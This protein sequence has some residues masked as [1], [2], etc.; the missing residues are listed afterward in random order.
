MR[1]YLILAT[2]LINT[3][4]IG[5]NVLIEKVL[6]ASSNSIDL[7]SI[8]RD[9]SLVIFKSIDAKGLLFADI[10]SNKIYL[11]SNSADKNYSSY[12]KLDPVYSIV[13]DVKGKAYILNTING[14]LQEVTS[15]I[16]Q[17]TLP[18][19]QY[20]EFNDLY[21]GVAKNS[22]IEYY[23]SDRE[24]TA[25]D[26]L[27]KFGD[28]PVVSVHPYKKEFYYTVKNA[29]NN[30]SVAKS[31]NNIIQNLRYPINYGESN[32]G[33]LILNSDSIIVSRKIRLGE[34]ELALIYSS[35]IVSQ[36]DSVEL[37]KISDVETNQID[38]IISK[39][40]FRDD[41]YSAERERDIGKGRWAT[42]IG[43][44]SDALKAMV[45]LNNALT[46]NPNSFSYKKD[47]VY[48]ILGPKREQ[49]QAA[50]R[51][52]VAFSQKGITT[53]T[54]DF[55]Y[56]TITKP[57]DVIIRLKCID[58]KSGVMPGYNA[59]FYEY[60]S[61]SVVKSATIYP[62]EVCYFSYLPEYTLGLT[63]NSIGYLPQSIKVDPRE[64]R[65]TTNRIEKI[66][67]LNK[68]RSLTQ[69]IA[70][71]SNELNDP[72]T[73]NRD[74]IVST[75]IKKTNS[76]NSI[77]LNNIYFGFDS[78]ILSSVAKRELSLIFNSI[79]NTK[80]ILISGHTDSKGSDSYNL[81]LSESRAR[82]V[83]AFITSLGYKGNLRVIGKG[84]T[85]PIS[86]ND[87]ALG[88]SKNRRCVI[89]IEN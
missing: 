63:I 52:S 56:D 16:G 79:N 28:V 61:N 24:I 36:L 23:V 20:N 11:D 40:S 4:A 64:N 14:T 6:Y 81:V 41:Q 34:N 10:R 60:T 37:V 22:L 62:E 55:V 69:N 70:D 49:K 9:K 18:K 80:S 84:E 53:T 7:L 2:V 68:L 57:A 86:N 54:Y 78:A 51:D 3:L 87:T 44:T 42:V 59:D 25:T 77:S 12:T 5:Q 45:T 66:I 48:F 83:G 75:N 32:N 13:Q 47:S 89:S 72:L 76:F 50:E 15:N 58:A 67:F 73:V 65:L 1:F 29:S 85:D 27:I 31:V 35:N 30:I 8:D 21:Y 46:T 88:R 82:A 71:N 38:S 74:E 19:I 39:K 43:K 33:F 17:V 26:T